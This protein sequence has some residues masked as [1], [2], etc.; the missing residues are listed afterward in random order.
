MHLRKV[1]CSLVMLF[2]LAPSVPSQ[3]ASVERDPQ[4][5]A[6]ALQAIGAVGGVQGI[7]HIRDFTATGTITYFWAGQRVSGGAIIR[8]KGSDQFRLDAHLPGG[9]RSQIHDR[10]RGR[11]Q[12]PDGNQTDI[13]PLNLQNS[14]IIT[15]P[16][17]SL[18]ALVSD[19]QS[20]IRLTSSAVVSGR[21]TH[22]IRVQKHL[23]PEQDRDGFFSDRMVTEYFV[24]AQSG[25]IA[26]ISG[27]VYSLESLDR[28]FPRDV[29]FEDYELI[30][31]VMVPRLVREKIAGQRVWEFHLRT[32]I[33]NNG[34]RDADFEI[35]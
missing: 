10:G 5:L 32:I 2:G 13:P 31:G 25:L 1:V 20:S 17:L 14:E 18:A 12:A 11:M 19:P 34:H 4:G 29:E 28:E 21:L 6:L 7:G 35:R 22:K 27:R 3:R 33:F 15:F 30:H 8:A 23:S 26:K 24:D 16:Y 9:T